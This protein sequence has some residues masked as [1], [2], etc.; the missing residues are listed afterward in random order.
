MPT[1]ITDALI[2]WASD[3]DANALDQAL[4]TSRLPI[5]AGPVALMPDA[6][7]GSAPRSGSVIATENAI[8]PPPS[9]STSA[10]A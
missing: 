4:R 3:L 1:V 5:L 10:A 7:W 8:L 6:H 9:A 2:S